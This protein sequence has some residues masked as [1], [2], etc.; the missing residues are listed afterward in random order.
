MDNYPKTLYP[1]VGGGSIVVESPEQEKRLGEGWMVHPPFPLVS[2]E[3]SK[4]GEMMDTIGHEP[5]A[6]APKRRGRPKKVVELS[7]D[8][9]S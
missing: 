7:L 6:P 9:I 2:E 4:F 3:I 1:R 8:K 5:E